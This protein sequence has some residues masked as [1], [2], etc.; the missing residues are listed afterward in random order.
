MLLKRSL[1]LAR[2][3]LDLLDTEEFV[4]SLTHGFGLGAAAL[5]TA[6]LVLVAAFTGD[7]WRVAGTLVFGG[8]LIFLYGASTLYHGLLHERLKAWMRRV[9]HFG[10]KLLIAGSYTPFVLAHLR[11]GPGLLLGFVVWGLVALGVVLQIVLPERRYYQVSLLLYLA[12]GFACVPFL[13]AMGA[14]MPEGA[15]VLLALGGA[16]YVAGVGFFVWESL[17]FS[18]GI[19]HLFVLGGSA[20]H[21]VAVLRYVVLPA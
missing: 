9:D 19:W 7:V 5:G 17:P 10:V 12:M 8:S 18:H 16:S 11:D 6:V 4:N 13:D 15:M 14:S 3:R 21:Y 1:L 20:L 2:D